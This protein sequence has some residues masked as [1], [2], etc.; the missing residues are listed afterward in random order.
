MTMTADID[1]RL[2]SEADV[3]GALG[4]SASCG[5]NQRAADWH[6]LL[7]I[8]PSGAF[9]AA[10]PEA[11]VGTAIGIDYGDYGWIAMMLVDPAL[12]GRGIG[13]RLLEAAMGAVPPGL[14]IRLD[15]TPLGRPLYER[16]GFELETAL[17]R[18][19]RPPGA[20]APPAVAGRRIRPMSDAD[21]GAVMRMDDRMSGSHRHGALRWAFG[22]APQY[23]WVDATRAD[24]AQYCLGRGGR[25]FDHVGPIVADGPE[26]AIALATSAVTASAGHAV[27]IDAYDT[28]GAFTSWLPSAGFEPQ[29]P[30]YR[31]RRGA[32]RAPT[33]RSPSLTEFAIMGPEFS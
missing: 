29:R 32:A 30:L 12:R 18:H 22:D 19:V 4:L 15:A 26:T 17:T 14:P 20:P 3:E 25:L 23:A 6:M 28:H 11:I 7:Q 21:L 9:A 1:I 33:H 24:R 5:W 8:A 16:Y 13:A 10:T 31:M 2:L 27:V